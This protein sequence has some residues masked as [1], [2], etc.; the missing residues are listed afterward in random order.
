MFDVRHHPK[1]DPRT[2]GP[3][4]QW[5]RLDRRKGEE[6]AIHGMAPPSVGLGATGEF[7][8]VAINITSRFYANVFDDG[9]PAGPGM[10]Y[11]SDCVALKRI[12]CSCCPSVSVSKMQRPACAT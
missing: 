1:C 9:S 7:R 11:M 5:A 10:L 4:E 2:A 8:A 6:L 3:F 12:S